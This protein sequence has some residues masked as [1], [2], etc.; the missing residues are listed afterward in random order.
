MSECVSQSV[1]QSV[2][3]WESE[4][5]SKGVSEFHGAECNNKAECRYAKSLSSKRC[6]TECHCAECCYAE[7]HCA[8]C[9]YASVVASLTPFSLSINT[10]SPIVR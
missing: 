2:S 5:G 9:R 7:C 8:E 6:C 3:Q 4:V 1:S 10:S